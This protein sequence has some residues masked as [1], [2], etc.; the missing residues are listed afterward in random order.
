MEVF[1]IYQYEAVV[2]FATTLILVVFFLIARLVH[3]RQSVALAFALMPLLLTWALQGIAAN[4]SAV[5]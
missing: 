2:L 5:L 1:G 3:A 4:G